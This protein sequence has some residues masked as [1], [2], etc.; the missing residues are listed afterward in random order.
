MPSVP[1]SGAQGDIQIT[2]QTLCFALVRP[3]DL[4]GPHAKPPP[5]FLCVLGYPLASNSV[6][7][8]FV[9]PAPVFSLAETHFLLGSCTVCGSQVLDLL[10]SLDLL[11]LLQYL[12][13]VSTLRTSS[14]PRIAYSLNTFRAISPPKQKNKNSSCLLRPYHSSPFFLFVRLFLILSQINYD[15]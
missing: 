10:I 1:L 2:L 11:C 4:A 14:S 7:L 13:P 6:A 5:S 12:P 15:L 8:G 9:I 3:P